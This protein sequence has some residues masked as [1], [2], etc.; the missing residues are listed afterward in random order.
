MLFVQTLRRGLSPLLLATALTAC[1]P[2]Y[3]QNGQLE[4]QGSIVI[5]PT[6]LNL[7]LTDSAS[8]PCGGGFIGTAIFPVIVSTFDARGFPIGNAN[9]TLQLDFSPST[10]YVPFPVTGPM[11]LLDDAGRTL[12]TVTPP[13]NGG[14]AYYKTQTDS[15]G[16]KRFQLLLDTTIGCSY[17]GSL[18]VDSGTIVEQL[19]VTATG[20]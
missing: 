7:D 16:T 20:N 17:A 5:S 4:S 12:L 19:Q 11:S 10:T 2:D 18:T 8:T 9:I 6:D 1:G 14:F 13:F 15:E 3:S